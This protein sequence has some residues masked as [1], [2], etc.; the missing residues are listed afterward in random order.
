MKHTNVFL[1][2]LLLASVLLASCGDADTPATQTSG[3][4]ETVTETDT[5]QVVTNLSTLPTI[6]YNGYEFRVQMMETA[7][8]DILTEG[9]ET[10]DVLNDTVHRRNRAIEE[11]YNITIT[12]TLDGDMKTMV[13]AGLDDTNL[14]FLNSH[15]ASLAANGY[16]YCISDLPEVDLTAAWWDQTCLEGLSI[17]ENVYMVT[18]DISPRSLL[19]SSCL[20]FNRNLFS[21]YDMEYPYALAADGKWTIDKFAE[22]T[23]GLSRDING[24]GQFTMDADLFGLTAWTADVS[25]SLYFGAGCRYSVKDAN[26]IPYVEFDM[27]RISRAY[28]SM[29]ALLVEQ[30]AHYVTDMALHETTYECFANGNAFFCEITLLKIDNFLRGMEDD[31]GMLPIPKLDESQENYISFVNAAGTLVMMPSSAEDP[32]RT[33]TILEALAAGASDYITPSL[34]EV[35]V[36]NKNARDEE[37]AQMVDLIIAHRVFDPVYINL[38]TGW[39][40]PATQ[41]SEKKS[42]IVSAL[43]KRKK[44]MT[45]ELEKISEAYAEQ[46]Q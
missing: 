37:S 14:F 3:V 34:Y 8:E 29:Y 6:D 10:G 43:E 26:D 19:F 22:L 7:E 25:F 9:E 23:K 33:A 17:A 12:A 41:L 4:S 15:S 44:V 2:S 1:F 30:Q 16:A 39:E 46:N 32:S 13:Q 27:D 21:A 24:D 38:L 45:R 35:I 42:N 28:E 40:T 36:K 31:Y 18:G 20:V 5:P 11:K